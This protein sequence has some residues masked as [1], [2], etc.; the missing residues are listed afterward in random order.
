M[1]A[2]RTKY[3]GPTNTKPSRIKASCEAR[4]IFVEWDHHLNGEANH[5]YAAQTLMKRLGWELSM[6]S[7]TL[8]DGTWAHVL[9]NT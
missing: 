8:K 4:T 7:G 6:A 3:I 9:I 2:I 1:Q 5:R